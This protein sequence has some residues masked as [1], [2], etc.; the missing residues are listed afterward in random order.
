[1]RN[2][3][4]GDVAAPTK[5]A[6]RWG[7]GARERVAREV[8]GHDVEEGRRVGHGPGQ[9]TVHGQVTGCVRRGPLLIRPREVLS[10]TRPQT[11]AGIRIEPP[12]SDP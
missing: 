10:P 5:P 9:R 6:G 3:P 8:A 2:R 1:M 12:P 7:Y 11:L 4:G